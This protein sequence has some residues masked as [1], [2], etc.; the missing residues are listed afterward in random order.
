MCDLRQVMPWR[1]SEDARILQGVRET[2]CKWSLIA[3]MLPGRS[4]NAVRNRWHRLEKA[5]RQRREAR[6]S[7]RSIEGYRCRKCGQF[8]KGH[9]CVGLERGADESD[10]ASR[11]G[12]ERRSKRR[13][14]GSSKAQDWHNVFDEVAE[15]NEFED[16]YDEYDGED[17]YSDCAAHLEQDDENA[18]MPDDDYATVSPD[19]P[20]RE[21]LASLRPM[22]RLDDNICQ[23]GT[24]DLLAAFIDGLGGGTHFMPEAGASFAPSG[25]R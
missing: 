24:S 20:T 8:K 19:T 13:R 14:R 16:E 23:E 4:D 5:E 22:A 10:S 3:Q 7:G 11:D 2:G 12:M 18:E 9:M 21:R 6:E 1:P 17:G 25:C 15:E